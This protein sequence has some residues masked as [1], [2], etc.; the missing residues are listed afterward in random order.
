[1]LWVLAEIAI[2]ACDLAEV[3]GF[4]IG[5]NLLFKI[6]LM[7][8]VCIAT[9][10]TF[11]FLAI[12]NFGVRRFEFIIMVLITVIGSCFIFEVVNSA[13]DWSQVAIGLAPS[14][15]DGALFVAIAII[16][17]TVMPHYLYLHSSLVQSRAFDSSIEGKRQACKFNF[18]DSVKSM[19]LYY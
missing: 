11:V 12:Q 6:P 17:A 8:G 14:L 9:L 3:L 10:D 5:L 15:P 13:P 4:V 19:M 18:I 7:W 2:V 1:M 16:G